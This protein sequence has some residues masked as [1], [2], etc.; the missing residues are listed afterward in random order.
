MPTVSILSLRFLVHSWVFLCFTLL[1]FCCVEYRNSSVGAGFKPGAL[2]FPSP[3]LKFLG[4]F[5]LESYWCVAQHHDVADARNNKSKREREKGKVQLCGGGKEARLKS[6]WPVYYHLVFFALLFYPLVLLYP[7]VPLCYHQQNVVYTTIFITYT[8]E[9]SSSLPLVWNA[10]ND[11]AIFDLVQINNHLFHILFF[12]LFRILLFLQ[13]IIG[14]AAPVIRM[15]HLIGEPIG[16]AA[17][18]AAATITTKRQLCSRRSRDDG[19]F[20]LSSWLVCLD[21]FLVFKSRRKRTNGSIPLLFSACLPAC[22]PA[23]RQ[24]P[25]NIFP[26]YRSIEP[27]SPSPS[28]HHL[29]CI[30]RRWMGR[31]NNEWE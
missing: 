24:T 14:D 2:L 18:E 16:T 10:A 3:D 9:T 29:T 26:L 4:F 6:R 11:D 5:F 12:L 7:S 28:R 19:E 31:R 1:H 23:C 17:P 13:L 21:L 15:D 8:N 25:S 27:L 22:L 20:L 30:E